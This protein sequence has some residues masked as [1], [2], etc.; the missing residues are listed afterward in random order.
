MIRVSPSGLKAWCARKSSLRNMRAPLVN[1]EQN[2]E[3]DDDDWMQ[4]ASRIV[5][6]ETVG[7]RDDHGP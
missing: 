1:P 7:S 2:M 3:K 5:R 4:K 6:R